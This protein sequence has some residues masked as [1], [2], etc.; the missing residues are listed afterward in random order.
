MVPRHHARRPPCTRQAGNS[1]AAL[2]KKEKRLK[3]AEAAFDASGCKG[4]KKK[5]TAHTG[6]EKA[7]CAPLKAKLD[8]AQKA[9]DECA[10]GSCGSGKGAAA[11]SKL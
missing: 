11:Q 7:A 4:F 3:D 6:A 8:E 2:A 10:A 9:R 1:T 5:D